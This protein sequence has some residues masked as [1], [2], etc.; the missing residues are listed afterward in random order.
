MH[1][2]I[3]LIKSSK[4]ENKIVTLQIKIFLLK[5]NKTKIIKSKRQLIFGSNSKL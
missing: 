5:T 3:I 4:S 1:Y 2:K